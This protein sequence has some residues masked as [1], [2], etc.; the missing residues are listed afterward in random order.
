[1]LYFSRES[2][3]FFVLPSTWLRLVIEELDYWRDANEDQPFAFHE[4]QFFRRRIGR[5]FGSFLPSLPPNPAGPQPTPT[6]PITT[7]HPLITTDGMGR[8]TTYRYQYSTNPGGLDVTTVD[9][10]TGNTIRYQYD[11]SYHLLDTTNPN[12]SATTSTY[13]ANTGGVAISDTSANTTTTVYD[14]SDNI[15]RS[16]PVTGD[17]TSSTY[18]GQNNRIAVTEPGSAGDSTTSFYDTNGNRIATTI[19]TRLARYHRLRRTDRRIAVTTDDQNGR[20]T[21]YTYDAANNYAPVD[22][23]TRSGRPTGYTYDGTG[24]IDRIHRRLTMAIDDYQY[25]PVSRLF[26]SGNHF[27]RRIVGMTYDI[28]DAAFTFPLFPN[29][30]HGDHRIVL[31]MLLRRR[32]RQSAM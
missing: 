20:T 30:R 9:P 16:I 15:V 18:D 19:D 23:I 14:A 32:T 12:G 5:D 17:V 22:S 11:A 13:D 26:Q 31:L 28:A 8:T 6:I 27:P 7:G 1:M 21:T 4:N 10:G 24:R 25:D 2:D 3:R 29:R